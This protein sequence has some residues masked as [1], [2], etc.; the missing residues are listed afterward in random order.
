MLIFNKAII[1]FPASFA[2]NKKAYTWNSFA[3]ED[4][5]LEKIVCF[6][7]TWLFWINLERGVILCRPLIL[8]IPIGENAA[9]PPQR[10]FAAEAGLDES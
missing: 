4:K 7:R 2:G 9:F 1:S 8:V 5:G 3:Q 6:F 10:G